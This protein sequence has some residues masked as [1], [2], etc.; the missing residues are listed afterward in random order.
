MVGKMTSALLAVCIMMPMSALASDYFGSGPYPETQ[1]D[2]S[3][4]LNNGNTN[5]AFANSWYVRGDV[6]VGTSSAGRFGVN[7]GLQA[8]TKESSVA[9]LSIGAGY[10]F[11]PNFRA[12]VTYQINPVKRSA[13]SQAFKCVLDYSTNISDYEYGDC[14]GDSLFEMRRQNV[15]LNGYYDIGTFGAFT[16]YVGAGIGAANIATKQSYTATWAGDHSSYGNFKVP[17]FTDGAD[18]GGFHGAVSY[19]QLSKRSQYNVAWAA[20]LGTSYTI[21]SDIKMDVGYR[22]LDAGSYTD[23]NGAS[24]KLTSSE[25]HV[26]MRM[27]FQ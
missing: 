20:M 1:S 9:G 11:S 12:D 19:D 5:G 8:G 6:S 13:A 10:Q 7:G 23:I 22:Y 3:V 4:D 25:L 16:P 21:N 27:S 18:T 14:I 15:L 2:P 24:T 17:V 26:G